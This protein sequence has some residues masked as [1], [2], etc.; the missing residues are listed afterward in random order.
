MNHSVKELRTFEDEELVKLAQG[1]NQ[2]ALEILIT[3]HC[4]TLRTALISRYGKRFEQDAYDAVQNAGIKAY[5]NI[6]SFKG[7]S[8]F[9]SWFYSIAVNE[10]KTIFRKAKYD[11]FDTIDQTYDDS[12]KKVYE[13]E[14]PDRQINPIVATDNKLLRTLVMK[15]MDKLS[16]K[17]RVVVY[18][19]DILGY[20][21]REVAKMFQIDETTVRTRL[22]NGHK[23]LLANL[24]NIRNDL[25][26]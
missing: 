10:A 2:Q 1:Q 9:Y 13:P 8:S 6:K 26:G 3:R 18:H 19:C 24:Q 22:H 11:R 25:L 17:L 5:K 16:D 20:K 23:K 7:D 14:D 21:P 12:D 4:A 15:Q